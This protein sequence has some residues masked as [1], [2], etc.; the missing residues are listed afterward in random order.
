[1][2]TVLTLT[3]MIVPADNDRTYHQ[4]YFYDKIIMGGKGRK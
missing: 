3:T 2:E 4:V 1:M